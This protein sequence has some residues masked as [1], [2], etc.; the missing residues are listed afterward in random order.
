[1]RDK[2][3]C[4]GIGERDRILLRSQTGVEWLVLKSSRD[5]ADM[6]L[7]SVELIARS[8][9]DTGRMHCSFILSAPAFH[10]FCCANGINRRL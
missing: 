2:T 4:F 7:A 10:L 9:A 5:D 6:K 1:M 3:S 8:D